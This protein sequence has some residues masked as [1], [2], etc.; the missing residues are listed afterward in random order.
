[1]LLNIKILKI[2]EINLKNRKNILVK[3]LVINLYDLL[4]VINHITTE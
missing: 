1:M 2:L 4:D 3:M